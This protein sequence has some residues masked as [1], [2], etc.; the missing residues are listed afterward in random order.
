MGPDYAVLVG[1]YDGDEKTDPAIYQEST[2]T[3]FVKLSASGYALGS[4]SGF[5][6]TD[7]PP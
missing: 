7:Y 1:D 2:S 5:D 3:W 6:S 4:F